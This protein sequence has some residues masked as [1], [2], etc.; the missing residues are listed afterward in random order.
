VIKKSL[1]IGII[2]LFLVS[3]LTPMVIGN[4][5]TETSEG[6]M[7]N[8]IVFASATKNDSNADAYIS[9]YLEQRSIQSDDEIIEPI[10]TSTQNYIS[11]YLEQRSI[12]SDDEII[13]PIETSTQKPSPICNVKCFFFCKVD[14][15]GHASYAE[16]KMFLD[17]KKV[18]IMYYKGGGD[19]SR[20]YTSIQGMFSVYHQFP[21]V[22]VFDHGN[23]SR[24]LSIV[25]YGFRGET[26]WDG[27]VQ[28]DDVWMDGSAFI[29]RVGFGN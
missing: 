13:E 21:F 11:R 9:R 3:A 6:K 29:V 22:K 23:F 25:A 7:L 28:D 26:S 16:E 20:G 18:A 10:E 19:W 14:S 4:N 12:Q 1:A 27:Y 8:N 2:L 5:N 24:V 17:G 15:S